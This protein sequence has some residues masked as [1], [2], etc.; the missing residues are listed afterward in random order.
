MQCP[1]CS[2]VESLHTIA[3]S[4][5]GLLAESSP[6]AARAAMMRDSGDSAEQ[7][8]VS[9]CNA[10]CLHA[11]LLERFTRM[12]CL[13]G[14]RAVSVLPSETLTDVGKWCS[15]RACVADM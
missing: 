14:C 12:V 7:E 1:S 13:G 5:P 2:A 10:C 3:E 11:L 6:S 8:E 9:M 4:L 15:H